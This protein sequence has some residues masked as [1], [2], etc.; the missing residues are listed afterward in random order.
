MKT[1]SNLLQLLALSAC[2]TTQFHMAGDFH[3]PGVRRAIRTMA[4]ASARN[5]VPEGFEMVD[6]VAL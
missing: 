1:A 3:M 5:I 2:L 6:A 4:G